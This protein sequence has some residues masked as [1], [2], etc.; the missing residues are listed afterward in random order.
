MRDVNEKVIEMCAWVNCFL[1]PHECV[2]ALDRFNLGYDCNGP[3]SERELEV[4]TGSVNGNS[5]AYL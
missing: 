5:N 4:S 3:F 2:Y 1:D